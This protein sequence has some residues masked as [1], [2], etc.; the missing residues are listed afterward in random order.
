MIDRLWMLGVARGRGQGPGVVATAPPGEPAAVGLNSD[1][2][3]TALKRCRDVSSRDH[4]IVVQP[5]PIEPYVES[6]AV[7]PGINPNSHKL[8][9]DRGGS[10]PVPAASSFKNRILITPQPSPLENH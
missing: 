10:K 7:D 6:A 2:M 3:R 8:V 5:K 1:K 4:E 9:A